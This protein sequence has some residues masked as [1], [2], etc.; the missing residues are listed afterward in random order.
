VKDMDYYEAMPFTVAAMPFHAMSGY[1]YSEKEHFPDTTPRSPTNSHGTIV[2]KPASTCR[3]TASTTCPASRA[4][5][6]NLN[7]PVGESVPRSG[8]N[9]QQ[10]FLEASWLPH[11][12]ANEL[13]LLARAQPHERRTI[14]STGSTVLLAHLRT[15]S[16]IA[17]A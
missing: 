10:L 3:T 11:A 16:G 2:S 17:A 15:S 8:S 12:G 9:R 14:S 5:H 4:D 7:R 13:S 6:A 1:P